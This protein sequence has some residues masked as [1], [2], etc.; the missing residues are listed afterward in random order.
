MA[1]SINETLQRKK[2][3]VEKEREKDL[4]IEHTPSAPIGGEAL[5]GKDPYKVDKCDE[6]RAR[7]SAK[8][9]V[10]GGVDEARVILGWMPGGDAP[11][12]VEV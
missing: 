1:H 2:K 4:N 11:F 7:Q 12:L 5:A 3:G 9:F 8:K 6:L 10:R